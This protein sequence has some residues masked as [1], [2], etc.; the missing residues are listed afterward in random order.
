M[1]AL[2]RLDQEKVLLS[3]KKIKTKNRKFSNEII[4]IAY[5]QIVLRINDAMRSITK[6]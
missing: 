5:T 2:N 4:V 1:R 6:K 3:S